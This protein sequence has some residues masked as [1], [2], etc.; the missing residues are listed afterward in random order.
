MLKLLAGRKL[1]E[2][3]E[4]PA[5]VLLSRHEQE[6]AFHAPTF[7]VHALVVGGLEWIR[8]EIEDLREAQ[9]HEGLLPDLEALPP[10]LGEDDLPLI[11]PKADQRAV[12]IGV[13]ELVAR[14][15]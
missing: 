5:N 1:L 10:L 12:V 7:D 11:I 8:A 9:G 3:G 6:E 13:E 4:E 15:R 2:G 14:A